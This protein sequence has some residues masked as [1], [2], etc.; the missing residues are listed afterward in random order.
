MVQEWGSG[1][2]PRVSPY[3]SNCSLF[4]NLQHPE[5]YLVPFCYGGDNIWG[6]VSNTGVRKYIM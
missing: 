6:P 5:R 1:G 2:K 4:H 3:S